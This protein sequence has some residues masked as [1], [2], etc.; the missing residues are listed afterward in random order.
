MDVVI[1]III[2]NYNGEQYL[3]YAIE[4]VLAQTYT[5]WELILVDDGSTDGSFQV[6]DQYRQNYSDK[7]FI[8]KNKRNK[9]VVY[10]RN[11]GAEY[12]S[13]RYLSFLDSDDFWEKEKLEK[14]MDFMKKYNF[15]VCSTGTNV[16]IEKGITERRRSIA[17][18]YHNDFRDKD[19]HFL[20]HRDLLENKLPLISSLLISRKVFFKIGCFEVCGPYNAEDLH[21]LL[22]L[23]MIY[24]LG[25]LREKLCTYR[26][27]VKSYSYNVYYRSNMNWESLWDTVYNRLE[28]KKNMFEEEK[29][30]YIKKKITKNLIH[31]ILIFTCRNIHAFF[32]PIYN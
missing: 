10:S 28:Q 32:R 26:L 9:G 5:K 25:F 27:H 21:L 8:I 7:I 18:S 17:D 16:I 11:I 2:P 13:G 6:M 19:S 22:K 20:E 15:L 3:K 23:S 31:K 12:S 30:K 1:S 24:K 14:Q 4:S 29:L